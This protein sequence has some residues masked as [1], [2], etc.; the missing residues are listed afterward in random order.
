MQPPQINRK[1]PAT[2]A[3]IAVHPKTAI[4]LGEMSLIVLLAML[5]GGASIVA[6]GSYDH[7]LDPIWF[8][9]R[10][11]LVGIPLVIF[12][13][14]AIFKPASILQPR[15]VLLL[16]L[17]LCFGTAAVLSGLV[18]ENAKALNDGVWL[19]I[20]VPCLFFYAL[21]RAAGRSMEAVM[22]WG[23][24]LGHVPYAIG[25]VVL[26]PPASLP[27]AGVFSNSN[28][29]GIT[30]LT[31]CC[32]LLILLN[33]TLLDPPRPFR[34]LNLFG[35]SGALIL[36]FGL[37]SISNSRT[38]LLGGLIGLCVALYPAFLTL[39]RPRNL[40][41]LLLFGLGLA[42]TL[43]LYWGNDLSAMVQGLEAGYDDKLESN[44][45]FNGRSYIWGK[46]FQD[47]RLF[48]YGSNDYFMQQFNLG[49]HN[50]LIDI[51]G[52]NGLIAAYLMVIFALMSFYA[53]YRFFLEQSAVNPYAIAPLLVSILFWIVSMAESMF[54]ALGRGLTIAY[55]LS[56]GLMLYRPQQNSR[57][58]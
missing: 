17:W 28:Q 45:T 11:G 4:H 43:M 51:L 27:Y 57:L 40:A 26:S 37:I 47:A 2:A 8:R 55:L 35:L 36:T 6:L 24:I 16:L 31:I 53:A 15:F 1:S 46:T 30:M 32:G 58:G 56:I 34:T 54:G 7:P 5:M 49:G 21:P 12:I 9:V 50:S 25:S 33:K 29:L 52:Q 19:L 22:A 20:G 38:S 13:A 23:L 3:A 10:Y 44:D 14:T 42:G 18:N 48:G 41:R 39:Q